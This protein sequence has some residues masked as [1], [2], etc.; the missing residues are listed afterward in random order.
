LA[1]SINGAAGA[2]TTNPAVQIPGNP[3][4]GVNHTPPSRAIP[5]GACDCHTH[6]FGTHAAF[7]LASDRVYTPAEAHVEDLARLQQALGLSRV[8]IVQPSPYG[9]DN[10]CTLDGIARLGAEWGIE[11][12]GVAVIDPARI[13]DEELAALHQG[14]IRGARV[15]LETSGHTDTGAA[16]RA[17]RAVSE[18]VAHLGW[19]VQTY[20]NLAVIDG[21]AE[22]VA[23]LPTPLVIDHFGR[24]EAAL[25]LRQKGFET[26]LRLVAA[27]NTYVKL[28][29]PHRIAEQTNTPEV[30]A[31]AR[32]L[33]DANADAMLWGTDWPHPGAWPGV[34]RTREAIEQFHPV[35]DGN[36]LNLFC[37]WSKSD[38]ELGKILVHNPAR[39]YDFN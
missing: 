15:N 14:G 18:R 8:V 5:A 9:E 37:S 25:G 29:A 36:A 22:I 31:V 20:T 1:E 12:R 30:A 6:V 38:A 21:L 11:A 7:P 16:Q 13:T 34:P 2:H 28:S 4:M 35:D 19:H 39:L 24:A 26:L 10:R 32:A 33:I 27:G 23:K 3:I 17:V